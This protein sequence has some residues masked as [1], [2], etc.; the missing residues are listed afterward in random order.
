MLSDGW[1]TDLLAVEIGTTGYCSNYFILFQ[2][3]RFEKYFYQN[4]KHH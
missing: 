3:T 1:S 4:Q 2:R